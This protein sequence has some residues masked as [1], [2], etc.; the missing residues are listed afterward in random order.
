MLFPGCNGPVGDSC[1]EQLWQPTSY[2]NRKIDSSAI[3]RWENGT[4]TS[5]KDKMPTQSFTNLSKCVS[6][7]ISSLVFLPFHDKTCTK[8]LTLFS[9]RTQYKP[10]DKLLYIEKEIV[11]YVTMKQDHCLSNNRKPHNTM[12]FPWQNY[13]S[14]KIIQF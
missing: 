7:V 8:P 3:F 10:K 14:S 11:L 2:C 12:E 1:G 4:K 5:K 9:K 13:L 6:Y